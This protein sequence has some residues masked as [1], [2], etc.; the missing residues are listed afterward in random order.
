MRQS[1]MHLA[2]I[3]MTMTTAFQQQPQGRAWP[4]KLYADIS[5]W[6]D[7]MFEN[8]PDLGD[9][10]RRK[11]GLTTDDKKSQQQQIE[12][13]LRQICVLPF[14]LTDIL[15]Q[16]ETKELCLY[17]ERFHQLFDYS[18]KHHAGIVA[19]GYIANEQGL[20]QCMP[21][22]EIENY[23]VMEGSED[24]DSA[25]L[26]SSTGKSILATIRVVGRATLQK[27]QTNDE[28][29]EEGGIF[30]EYITAWCTEFSDDNSNSNTENNVQDKSVIDVCNELA[31]DIDDM[32]DSIISLEEQAELGLDD[33]EDEDEDDDDYLDDEDESR[34]AL[35][36]KAYQ[37]AISSD[38]QGYTS[39]SDAT[40]EKRDININTSR[41]IQELTAVS[42]AY[43]SKEV[44]DDK[45]DQ[46]LLKFRLQALNINNL[47]DR[48]ILIY[49]MMLEQRGK[50]IDKKM[51]F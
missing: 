8:P 37:V 25:G 45:S 4:T 36:K 47:L 23:R 27:I 5:E 32:F 22:C 10:P 13:P 33:D 12:Q 11:E 18:T 31:N 43:L 26:Y 7:I 21:L 44:W 42:W 39:S 30:D 1:V 2:A 51:E 16:G 20:L 34:K 35:F 38:T 48:L 29:K 46:E 6:R 24:D 17:E 3:T 15:L 19:M 9:S 28:E 14:P 40:T 41:S 50:L 49:K